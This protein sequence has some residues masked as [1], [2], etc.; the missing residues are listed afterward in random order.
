MHKLPFSI[1]TKVVK[2][3]GRGKTLG[4]PTINFF[5]EESIPLEHGVYAGYIKFSGITYPAAIH[6]G[7]RPVFMEEEVTLEAYILSGIPKVTELGEIIFE[8]KLREVKSFSTKEELVKQM[9]Q[10]VKN[11]RRILEYQ[12]L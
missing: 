12:K 2:G 8:K 4:F 5:V 10:D 7:P 11:A 1:I 6:F 3:K 9:R